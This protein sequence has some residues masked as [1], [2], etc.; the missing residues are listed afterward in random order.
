[1]KIPHLRKK[2]EVKTCHGH[3]WTDNYSWVHQ[4]NCLEILRDKSKLDPAVRKYLEEENAYTEKNMKETRDLQKK[5]FKEIEDRIKLDDESLKYKDKKF[6][7]WS[8][9]TKEGNYGK[10]LSKKT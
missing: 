2:E 6:E 9:T 5:L 4:N 7:Y 1:M 3:S 10:L 8:K